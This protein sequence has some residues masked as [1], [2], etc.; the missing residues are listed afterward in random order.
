MELEL[1]EVV[2]V[3]SQSERLAPEDVWAESSIRRRRLVPLGWDLG[4]RNSYP[5]F[6]I[7]QDVAIHLRQKMRGVLGSTIEPN[8]PPELMQGL[9]GGTRGE[10]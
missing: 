4:L 5:H 3:E 8:D 9:P 7:F 2:G 1:I 10:T 6:K